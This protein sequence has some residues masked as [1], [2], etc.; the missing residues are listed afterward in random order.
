M[1]SDVLEERPRLVVW[2]T[3][4]YDAIHDIGVEKFKRILRK[5]IAKLREAS[6]DVVL[7]DQFPVP[8]AERF[9]HLHRMWPHSTRSQPRP[10]P[11]CSGGM[12]CWRSCWPS[13]A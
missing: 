1:D 10:A 3:G 7:M 5:G 9:P 12:P 8:R 4:V 6:I 13:A 11:R 2:Q